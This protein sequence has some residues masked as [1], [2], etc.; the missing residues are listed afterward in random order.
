MNLNY[1]ANVIST[2]C[3]YFIQQTCMYIFITYDV[4]VIL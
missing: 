4:K 3:Q 1:V 2:K